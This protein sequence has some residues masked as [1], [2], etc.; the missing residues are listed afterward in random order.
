MT[1]PLMDMTMNPMP[2]MKRRMYFHSDISDHVLFEGWYASSPG[3]YFLICLIIV[4]FAVFRSWLTGF[5]VKRL[6][7][8]KKEVEESN[9]AENGLA[10]SSKGSHNN[11]NKLDQPFLKNT[12]K[13]YGIQ[14][15]VTMIIIIII[16]PILLLLNLCCCTLMPFCYVRITTTMLFYVCS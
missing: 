13:R 16:V 2:M 5:R 14:C 12:Q 9:S 10:M 6:N 1:N 7:D 8:F 3:M 11:N 4:T 15:S